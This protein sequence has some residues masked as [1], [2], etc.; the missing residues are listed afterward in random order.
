M[1]G[2]Q[3]SFETKGGGNTTPTAM[4]ETGTNCDNGASQSEGVF[5]EPTKPIDINMPS[6]SKGRERRPPPPQRSDSENSS[7]HMEVDEVG[8]CNDKTGGNTDI[9]SGFENMEVDEAENTTVKK[10]AARQRTTSSTSEMSEEQLRATIARVLHSTFTDTSSETRL[11]L[12]ETAKSLQENPSVRL[13]ALISNTIQEV[14]AIST[15]GVDPFVNL[16]PE[17]PESSP[18]FTGSPTLN[19]PS[20]SPAGSCPI[21]LLTMRPPESSRPVNIHPA[22]LSLNFLMDSYNRVAIEERNHPK[23]SSVPPLS[24]LL[25]ELR[26]QLVQHATLVLRG[27]VGTRG[28]E[29]PLLQPML[30]QTIPRGF[31][32]E[33]VSRTYQDEKVFTAV[34]GPV[35]QVSTATNYFIALI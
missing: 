28:R 14:L 10:D 33:L 30:Q 23:K 11:Y 31:V 34:F 13:S 24:N 16:K 22:E 25:A 9:D 6:S 27:Y 35:L 15:T 17:E 20:V 4:D 18:S 7:T 8:S 2:V 19:S 3:M 32:N 12:P 29:S 26:M 1:G 5:K 21:P